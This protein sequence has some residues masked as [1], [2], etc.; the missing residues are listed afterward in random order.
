M[1]VGVLFQQGFTVAPS[2]SDL[3]GELSWAGTSG[4]QPDH[5]LMS[6]PSLGGT[7][8]PNDPD[9]RYGSIGT[10]GNTS[11]AAGGS[12]QPESFDVRG[13]PAP[14]VLL[15]AFAGIGWVALGASARVGPVDA[16]LRVGNGS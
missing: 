9:A 7:S 12:T 10:L 1:A 5:P 2:D 15:L 3:S 11:A 16:R 4:I 13:S 6:G 8:L 14:W